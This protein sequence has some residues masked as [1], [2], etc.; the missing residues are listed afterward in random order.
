MPFEYKQNGIKY[1]VGPCIRKKAQMRSAPIPHQMLKSNRPAFSSILTI[2]RDSISR[3][4]DGVG[5]R[6]D[7]TELAKE[8]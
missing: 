3:C 4:P 8:S 5:T 2:V 1:A 7:V 6:L